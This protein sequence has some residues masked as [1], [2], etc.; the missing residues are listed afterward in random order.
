MIRNSTVVLLRCC[1]FCSAQRRLC[2]GGSRT[3]NSEPPVRPT[4]SGWAQLHSDPTG[5]EDCLRQNKS[6]LSE[7][8]R[9][10]FEQ[11]AGPVAGRSNK[12]QQKKEFKMD[13]SIF[14]HLRRFGNG[15]LNP[16]VIRHR[17]G[18]PA[19]QGPRHSYAAGHIAAR[20]ALQGLH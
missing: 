5:V 6:N 4:H 16:R 10:V 18:D 11:S 13:M 1:R 7:A 17:L 8:C 3:P 15:F 20:R 2:P 14:L 12:R 19:S 9:S